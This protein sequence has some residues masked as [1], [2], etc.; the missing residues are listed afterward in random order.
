MKHRTV[1]TIAT[2]AER[3]LSLVGAWLASLELAVL[4]LVDV[5]VR[6]GV[7]HVAVPEDERRV[8]LD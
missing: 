4:A 2:P 1:L 5:P 3:D 8:A 7:A 6:T